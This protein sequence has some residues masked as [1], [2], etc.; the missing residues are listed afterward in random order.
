MKRKPARAPVPRIRNAEM[1]AAA[2]ARSQ[3]PPGGAP[4]IAF[5]GRSN[6]GKSSLL[7]RMVVRKQLAR[8]SSTPGKTR[9]VHWYRVERAPRPRRS[10]PT[11]SSSGSSSASGS[12]WQRRHCRSARSR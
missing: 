12:R 8:T 2:A 3:F 7:N 11:C 6:V 4:E 9:L 10:G 1:F 5:L